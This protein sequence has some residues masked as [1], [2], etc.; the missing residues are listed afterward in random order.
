MD[1]VSQGTLGAVASQ[2]IAGK[3]IA[4]ATALG[5]LGGLAPDLDIFIRSETD[6]LL[7]LEYHR[8][9]THA[10]VFI[11]IG[12]LICAII[13]HWLFARRK[14]L[15]FRRTLL[16]C[17]A[18]YATHALLDACTSYGTQLFWPFSTMR[19]AW[20]TMSIIDPLF[21]LPA[22][23][24]VLIGLVRKNP[25]YARFAVIWIFSYMAF[26]ITQRERTETAGHAL[27]E[28]RGHQPLRLEAKP[29]FGNQLLWKVVY[30][31]EDRFY[32]DGFRTGLELRHYPGDS[33]PKLEVTRDFPWLDPDSQQARDIERFSWFSDGYVA[34]HGDHPD[35]IADIRYSMVPN[36]IDAIWM[37]ELDPEAGPDQHAGYY[38]EHQTGNGA[39]RKLWDM[40]V[41]MYPSMEGYGDAD[42]G[43]TVPNNTNTT[44]KQG[45]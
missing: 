35:R 36:E 19:I 16:Y 42:A 8:Q 31:T 10:L 29:G 38:H 23:A 26:G 32:V 40:L 28:S 24:L 15:P 9:F 34:V 30:E 22:L 13:A 25:L 21:T 17:T 5:F 45:S 14:G 6:P 1:P 7:F 39:P 33:I 44:F 37:I 11:P 20:N 4:V 2:N 3:H 41:D 18:G 27:A 43:R 12:G